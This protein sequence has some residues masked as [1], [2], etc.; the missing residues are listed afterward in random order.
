MSGVEE[1]SSAASDTVSAKDTGRSR[2]S[3]R[4]C[5]DWLYQDKELLIP[6]KVDITFSGCRLVDSFCWNLLSPLTTLEFASKTC[7]DLN[8]PEGFKW[9][10]CL[11]IQE[12]VDAFLIL[13]QALQYR[14]KELDASIEAAFRQPQQI[15][16]GIRYNMLDYAENILWDVH[17]NKKVSPE[18]FARTTCDDLG[19]PAQMEPL[20]AF[21]IRESLLRWS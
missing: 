15:V 18:K 13:L 12:Q 8:L 21:R 10:L 4:S 19:L 2:S 6:V 17:A 7:A 3:S 9:K 16:I 5:F 20:I 1:S 11:Q 14:S